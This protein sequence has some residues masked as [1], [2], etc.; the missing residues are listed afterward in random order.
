M[1]WYKLNIVQ[2]KHND[3]FNNVKMPHVSVTNNHHQ[4]DISVQG[5]DMFSTTFGTEHVM[6]LYVRDVVNKFPD[7]IFRARTECSYHTSR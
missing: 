7:C 1:L 6:S 5:H 2:S 4:A 3:I